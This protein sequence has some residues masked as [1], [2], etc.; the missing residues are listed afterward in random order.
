[1]KGSVNYRAQ[2]MILHICD[3]SEAG[4]NVSCIVLADNSDDT[5]DCHFRAGYKALIKYCHWQNK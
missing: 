2:L 1:M 4:A 5:C 3:Y